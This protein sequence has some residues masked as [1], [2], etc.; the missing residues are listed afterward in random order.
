[1]YS[2][3]SSSDVNASENVEVICN[4][5]QNYFFMIFRITSYLKDEFHRPLQYSVSGD[6]QD[7]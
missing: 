3:V 2:Y 6:N 5:S 4:K 7:V 1:M